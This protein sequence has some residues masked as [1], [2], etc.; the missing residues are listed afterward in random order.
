[1]DIRPGGDRRPLSHDAT[2]KL[3][4]L[5]INRTQSSRWQSIAGIPEDVFEEHMAEIGNQVLTMRT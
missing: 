2:M 4:D 5:G 3:D 1:M